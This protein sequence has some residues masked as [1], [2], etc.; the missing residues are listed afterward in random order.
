MDDIIKKEDLFGDIYKAFILCEYTRELDL[1]KR[2]IKIAEDG[3]QKKNIKETWSFEGVCY[4]IAKSILDY[5][6]MAYDNL[7]LGHF[8]ATNMI[9]RAILENCVFLDI[10]I[11]NEDYELWKYYLAHS[12]RSTIYKLNQE[13]KQRDIDTLN[14]FFSRYEIS[15]DFYIKQAGQ[16]KPYI[17]RPYGWT[18]KINKEFS[19]VGV[20]KLVSEADHHGFQLMSDY[21]HGTAFHTKIE[22]SISVGNMMSIF[23]SLY[24]ELYRMVTLFCMDTV[25]DSFYDIADEM[26]SIIYRFIDYEETLFAND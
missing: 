6:K 2:L 8:H 10:I 23:T 24:I 18:Y 4:S 5:T 26:E 13:P 21:S 3:L 15:E 17:C 16:K 7:L 11:N 25:N 9:N 1:I 20:C 22:S 19:S 12:Y 14:D